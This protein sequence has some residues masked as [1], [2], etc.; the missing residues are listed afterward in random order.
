MHLYGREIWA[1]G[2]NGWP[3]TPWSTAALSQGNWGL[4]KNSH[5]TA[6]LQF[7]PIFSTVSCA[8]AL[9]IPPSLQMSQTTE[10]R[11]WY[12][13]IKCPS[14]QTHHSLGHKASTHRIS[15]AETKEFVHKQAGFLII[16]QLHVIFTLTYTSQGARHAVRAKEAT[17]PESA[18]VL[19]QESTADLPFL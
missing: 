1:E 3:P 11:L 2:R 13:N 16:L 12:K 4:H 9:A 5:K 7:L 8:S 10:T 17:P 18:G 15:A 6:N 19:T 14:R